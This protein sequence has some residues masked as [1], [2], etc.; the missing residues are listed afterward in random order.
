M[1]L[2]GFGQRRDTWV[3]IHLLPVAW[4]FGGKSSLLSGTLAPTS[5]IWGTAVVVAAA[6]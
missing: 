6:G 2:D 5:L 1:A 4:C 3:L